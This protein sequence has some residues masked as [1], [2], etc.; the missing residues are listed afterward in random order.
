MTHSKLF[1]NLNRTVYLELLRL[2]F[3]VRIMN[4]TLQNQ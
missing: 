1:L 2:R 3:D 4:Q